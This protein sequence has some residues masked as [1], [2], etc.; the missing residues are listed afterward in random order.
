[1]GDSPFY[2][3]MQEEAKGDNNSREIFNMTMEDMT[4]YVRTDT[5]DGYQRILGDE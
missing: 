2:L 4:C 5:W 1:M 3:I